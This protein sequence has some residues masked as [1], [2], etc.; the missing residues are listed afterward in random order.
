[1]SHVPLTLAQ[2]GRAI[3]VPMADLVFVTDEVPEDLNPASKSCA[4][5][6]IDGKYR[7]IGILETLD[8]V[9]R[10]LGRSA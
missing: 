2:N 9:K 6:M 10:L 3:S 5:V 4:F 8:D 1:M 7:S